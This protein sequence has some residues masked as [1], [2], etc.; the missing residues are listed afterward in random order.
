MIVI[1]VLA[2]IVL[3]LVI[4]GLLAPLESL[5]WWARD[6]VREVR[7]AADLAASALD[8][9]PTPVREESEHTAFVVFFSGIGI[10]SP[11]VLPLKEAPLVEM[12]KERIGG[13]CVI[14]DVFPYSPTSTGL[15]ASR[16]FSWLW[17]KLE[18]FKQKRVHGNAA[19]LINIRNAFQCFVSI[20]RRYGPVYNLG[21]AQQIW[22]SLTRHGYTLQN[23]KPVVILGWSGGAQIAVGSAWYLASIGIP[24]SV[25]SMA[26]VFG[27]DPGLDRVQH[28]WHLYGSL[29]KVHNRA[30]VLAPGR[31]PMARTSPWWKAVREGRVTMREIGPLAHSGEYNYFAPGPPMPDGREPREHT[32]DAIMN[33]LVTESFATDRTSS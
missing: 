6:G 3:I 2:V 4:A 20:D 7:T 29:D 28:L 14:S 12:L 17:R 24:V 27:A 8:H 11:D 13:A 18:H 23:P 32:V 19:F 33:L 16:Q 26:G 22:H 31:W 10:A 9:T 1:Q 25:I 15:T 5:S 30:V 21:V